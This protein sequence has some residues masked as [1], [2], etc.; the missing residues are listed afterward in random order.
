MENISNFPPHPNPEGTGA[1]Y[2]RGVILDK[3]ILHHDPCQLSYLQCHI[4]GVTE[5]VELGQIN[6]HST[7]G[8]I[9]P[10]CRSLSAWSTLIPTVV[11][12]LE[13]ARQSDSD[14]ASDNIL[15]DES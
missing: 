3:V 6:I 10:S 15:I 7:V 14:T 12:A 9:L 13:T 1:F 11:V 4:P 8:R 5:N 2:G